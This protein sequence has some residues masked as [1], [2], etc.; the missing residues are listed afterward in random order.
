MSWLQSHQRKCRFTVLR[1]PLLRAFSVFS[2]H[3]ASDTPATFK[4]LKKHLIDDYDVYFANGLNDQAYSAEM[5][6]D[7]FLAF[8]TFLAD[9]FKGNSVIK[10]NSAFV[11]QYTIIKAFNSVTPIDHMVR[12]SH[13]N[14]DLAKCATL[15]GFEPQLMPLKPEVFRFSLDSIVNEAHH[16]LIYKIYA[17]DYR[18][19]NFD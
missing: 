16:R 7:G 8:L 18:Y 2:L 15:M 1:D 6:A 19:L 12:E 13:I 17:D 14:E 10:M 4:K 11:S 3:I 5:H 9:L